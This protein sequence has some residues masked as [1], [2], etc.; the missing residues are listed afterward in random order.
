MAPRTDPAAWP[1]LSETLPHQPASF[2]WCM[3]CA[4]VNELDAWQ[5]HDDHDRPEPILIVLCRP[6][7]EQIIEPHPRLYRLVHRHEPL[8]GAMRDLCRDCRLQTALRCRSPL[9]KANGGPGLPITYPRP[10]VAFVDGVRGGRRTGWRE[11]LWQGPPESCG[12][13]EPCSA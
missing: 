1:R 9:L 5:E 11:T 4:G 8:P 6:C 13:R 2:D 3:R 10:A 7:A 12:G